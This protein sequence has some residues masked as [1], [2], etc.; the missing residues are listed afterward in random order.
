[1]QK[2]S[3]NWWFLLWERLFL[4]ASSSRNHSKK[5][6][7]FLAATVLISKPLLLSASNR[8]SV[9]DGNCSNTCSGICDVG[10]NRVGCKGA[11]SNACAHVY[12]Q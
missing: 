1:M 9:C 4:A 11:C 2:Q 10:C 6:L 3:H 12:N 5:V 7:P 8:C